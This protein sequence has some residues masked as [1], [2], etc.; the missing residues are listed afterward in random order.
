MKF[1]RGFAAVSTMIIVAGCSSQRDVAQG[2]FDYL[3]LEESSA[4]LVPQGMN[5]V[6]PHPDY[7]IPEN[8]QYSGRLG[9]EQSIR[10]PRQVMPLVPGSRTEESS[11]N[12][13]IW[14]DAIEDMDNVADWVWRELLELVDDYD[15]EVESR[16]E[17][18][19]LQTSRFNLQQGS[20]T[21]SGFFNRLRRQ[22]DVIESEQAFKINMEAPEHGR[23]AMV[24]VT[25]E[26]VR[27][28]IGGEQVE[29]PLFIQRQLE[30]DFLNQLSLRLQRGYEDERVASVRATRALRHAESPQGNPAYALDTG[31]DSGWVMMPGVFSYLGFIVEDLNQRDGLYYVNYQPGGTRGWFSRLAFWRSGETPLGI[32]RGDYEFE[33]DEVEGV[34]YIVIRRD[35]ELLS[36]E[37]LDEMFPMFAEAFSEHSD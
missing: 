25:A 2:N 1:W 12:S 28:L 20:Q 37:Q 14:F 3:E 30:A 6:I 13:R 9:R 5:P 24:E 21:K 16:V 8:E 22:R 15:A 26:N 4:I 34:F 27:W 10:S 23:T 19:F 29:E 32:P 31:F 18:D 17:Q 11:T 35:D 7:I 33:V 36:E